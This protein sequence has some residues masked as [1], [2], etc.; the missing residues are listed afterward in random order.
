MSLYCPEP[1]TVSLI[2]V[3][4]KFTK[5]SVPVAAGG[6]CSQ[7]RKRRI[8]AAAA[9]IPAASITSDSASTP[10]AAGS[11]C[12]M[13][14]SSTPNSRYAAPV[15][16][17]I[18]SPPSSEY[19]ADAAS[20]CEGGSSKHSTANRNCGMRN[21]VAEYGR[22][23]GRTTTYASSAAMTAQPAGNSRPGRRMSRMAT[24]I[25]TAL[26]PLMSIYCVSPFMPR[27]PGLQ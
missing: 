7:S 27:P 5:S 23:S 17:H 11:R 19:S 26:S 4:R 14:I 6:M 22:S 1:R 24:I 18:S 9:I 3:S 12:D 8:T 2:A 13:D 10:G 16:R 21:I 15:G 25:R 20:A